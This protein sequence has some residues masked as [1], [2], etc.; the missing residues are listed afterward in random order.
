MIKPRH[1]DRRGRDRR[2][3][4]YKYKVEDE[5]VAERAGMSPSAAEIWR[6]AG[7]LPFVKEGPACEDSYVKYLIFRLGGKP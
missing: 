6:K 4:E 3:N 5:K 1:D 2:N 7:V